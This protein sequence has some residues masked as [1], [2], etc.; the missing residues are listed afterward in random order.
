[1]IS[2]VSSEPQETIVKLT[3]ADLLKPMQFKAVLL[4][5]C[6]LKNSEIAKSLGTT[7]QVIKNVLRDV[8]SRAGCG[9]TGGLVRRYFSEVASGHLDLGRLRREL[10]ELEARSAQN[11]RARLEDRLQR[12][13]GSD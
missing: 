8:Y 2:G 13:K 11:F 7:E 6:G 9:N 4:F 3:L 10:A 12:A 5:V 1:M